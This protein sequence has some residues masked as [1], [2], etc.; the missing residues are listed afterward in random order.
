M[1]FSSFGAF[2]CRTIEIG[3]VEGVLRQSNSEPERL[4]GS[5]PRNGMLLGDDDDEEL[6]KGLE[7]VMA[8]VV[9]AWTLLRLPC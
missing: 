9:V 4:V 7:V 8:P 6:E 2:I 1:R 3:V 5:D